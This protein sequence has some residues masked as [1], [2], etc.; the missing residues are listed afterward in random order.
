MPPKAKIC[1]IC[2][3]PTLLPGYA[4]HVVQ[5]KA[6]YE[7]REMAKPPKE[8]RPLPPDPSDFMGS[9]N[10]DEF[11]DEAMKSWQKTLV[12]CSF[13]GRKFLPD[14]L[15]IHNR[16]CTASN[17]A[18]RVG[19][20]ASSNDNYD[21]NMEY[22]AAPPRRSG[23][24]RSERNSYDIDSADYEMGKMSLGGRTQD[25]GSV[26]QYSSSGKYSQASKVGAKSSKLDQYNEFP[27]YAALVKCPDCGR[28]FNPVS[29]EK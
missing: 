2:G 13:C 9:S 5:C 8:R 23:Y 7:K 16:S 28:N 25:M 11:N 20:V 19:Q 17:P 21:R 29:F 18:K 3:R 24:E 14:K 1:Y 27:T 26:N 6:L 10:L 12:P 22:D 4:Q 15:A